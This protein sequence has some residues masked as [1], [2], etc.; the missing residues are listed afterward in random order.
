MISIAISLFAIAISTAMFVSGLIIDA[1]AIKFAR[2]SDEVNSLTTLISDEIRRAGYVSSSHQL[3]TNAPN[4]LNT[5]SRCRAVSLAGCSKLAY[6]TIITDQFGANEP[7]NSC[8]LLA[9]DQDNSGS[10]NNTD[11]VGFRLH[12]DAIEIRNIKRQCST[13]G[14]QDLSDTKFVTISNLSFRVQEPALSDS[15]TQTGTTSTC[16]PL[17][18]SSEVFQI[19]LAFSATLVESRCTPKQNP[20]DPDCVTLRVNKTVVVQNASYN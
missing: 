6:R 2:L 18:S 10:L 9:Y 5:V 17:A 4:P 1:K 12:D 14:W 20:A 8:I 15:C 19:N 11:Y 13:G 7:S 3:L 16:I